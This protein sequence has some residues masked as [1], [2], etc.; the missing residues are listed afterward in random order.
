MKR[1]MFVLLIAGF[2]ISCST[3]KQPNFSVE[4][5]DQ[6][7]QINEGAE[8][9]FF[10]QRA[11]KSPEGHEGEYFRGHYIHPLWDLDGNVIT[12]DYPPDHLHQRGIFWSWHQIWI[13]DEKIGDPWE[14]RD[15]EWNVAQAETHETEAGNLVLAVKVNWQSPLVKDEQGNE[16]P[17]ITEDTKITIYPR[18][19][20]YRVIDFDIKLLAM[21][22]DMKIGGSEDVKGYSGF[23]TRIV[24]PEDMKFTGQVGELEPQNTAVDGGAW[25]DMSGSLTTEGITGITVLSHPENPGSPQPW[26][27]RRQRSMQ[28]A[29]Y[30]GQHAVAFSNTQPTVLRYRL[31]LHKGG[32]DQEIIKKLYDEYK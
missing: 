4:Q 19:E 3:S 21:L 7:L 13:G 12:E 24:L 29:V 25:V 27:L 32:Y 14:I 8:K 6:G 9:V 16:K 10:Y 23:S 30:P 5:T 26:I 1:I 22:P 2:L 18:T 17:L 28:N 31:V 20:T 11:P 15:W